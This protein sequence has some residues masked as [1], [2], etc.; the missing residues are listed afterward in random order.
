MKMMPEAVV[1]NWDLI[2]DTGNAFIPNNAL[3]QSRLELAKAG[4]TPGAAS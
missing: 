3:E 4:Y 1:S 2:L